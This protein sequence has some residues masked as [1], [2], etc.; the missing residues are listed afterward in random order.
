MRLKPLLIPLALAGCAGL[1]AQPVLAGPSG[2][3]MQP[4]ADYSAGAIMVRIGASYVDPDDDVFS[5]VQSFVA[6]DPSTEDVVE[7]VPV[8]VGVDVDLDDD[9]TWYVS[10]AWMAMDHWGL[11]LYHSNDASLEADLYSD[12]YSGRTFIG[13]FSEGIG[14]FDTYTTSLFVNWYPLDTNC[15]I[16][17]YAGIGVSYVDIE[18]DFL[19]PVFDDP[20]GDFGLLRFGSD[21][22]WTAQIGVDF[23]FGPKSA[24]QV[25]A[26]AMY[27]DA[28][29]ELHMGFD[30]AT[31]PPGFGEPAVLPVRIRDDMDLD[32]WIF[33]LGV[34]YKFSF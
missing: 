13:D 14:D 2:Y 27:V 5:G 33:N 32:P 25:N 34:G 24:W 6:D 12:A 29:P 9:T 31:Q 8:D 21:F 11:E 10:F 26:S 16:Q 15:L 4:P 19:R 1:A 17:P 23:N 28:S 20:D 7:G 30:T 18:E 22:S 3:P